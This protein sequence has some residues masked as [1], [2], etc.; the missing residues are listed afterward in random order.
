M[1]F[2][3]AS[4]MACREAC[5]F[6]YLADTRAEVEED[7]SR[8]SRGSSVRTRPSH[9]YRLPHNT[10]ET[11][12]KLQGEGRRIQPCRCSIITVTFDL[13]F[14]SFKMAHASWMLFVIFHA[15]FTTDRFENGRLCCRMIRLTL[16]T[17]GPW[18]LLLS[19]SLFTLTTV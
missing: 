19:S 6:S 4:E 1:T 2:L 17:D 11:D 16:G 13:F 14:T 15:V 7:C 12:G 3:C 8:T 9:M 10:A 18:A 5:R